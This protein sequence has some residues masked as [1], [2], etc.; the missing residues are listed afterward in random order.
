MDLLIYKQFQM[1]KI[2]FSLKDI[3]ITLSKLVE[4]FKEQNVA[5]ID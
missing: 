3:E 5:E 2:M 4:T 1:K